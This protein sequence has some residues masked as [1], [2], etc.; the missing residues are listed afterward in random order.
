[1]KETRSPLL[2]IKN[3]DVLFR[4]GDSIFEA[5]R[6]LSFDVLPKQTVALV[7]ESGSGKSVSALSILKLLPYPLAHH[8]KGEILFEGQDLLKM[9]TK[10]LLKVRGSK[11]SMI[12]QEPMTSLNPL[13]TIE[14]QIAEVLILH[15]GM[16]NSA[17]CRP[18]I[19]KL[20]QMVGFTNIEERLS[21]YPHQLSGG[22]RQR[23]MIAI[24]LACRPK[25][26]IA[27]EPTTAVDVTTQAYILDLIKELQKEIEMSMLLITHDLGIVKKMADYTVVMQKGR[28]IEQAPTNTLFQSPKDSYTRTLINAFPEG[29]PEPIAHNAPELLNARGVTVQFVSKKGFLGRATSHFKAV[30]EADLTLREGETI[31]LV[32][33]SGSGKTTFAL[34]LL[35]LLPYTGQVVFT[36]RDIG[37]LSSKQLRDVRRK[38]QIVFQDP[39]GSLSPRMTVRDIVGE[40]LKVHESTLSESEYLLRTTLALREVGLDPEMAD[41]YP[42]EFSGG[43]RQ[44]IS[45][46]RAL[47]LKPKIVF[48]DE[49]TSAL[50]RAVQRDVLNLLR[51]LQKKYRLSYVFISHDLGVVRSMSHRIMVMQHGKVVE[52]GATED[53]FNHLQNDYTQKLLKAAQFID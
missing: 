12:F 32:G 2:A 29:T 25:I 40:G 42:H 1:M 21:A 49:P 24:A 41:R 9:P 6:D 11:I 22:Q 38:I 10:E 28:M 26:L 47:I 45:I 20:M 27:D 31:G 7:G 19:V 30:N 44:R 48:L 37:G 50:D 17:E 35:Q 46:A 52:Q 43:Q 53:V 39:F 16:K 4:Q 5:V 36:G 23:I 15:R 33:E 18:E 3:L 51:D 34:S 8:P 13:H 14:R